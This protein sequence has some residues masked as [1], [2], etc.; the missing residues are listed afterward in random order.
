MTSTADLPK[1]DETLLDKEVTFASMALDARLLQAVARVGYEHPSLVQCEWRAAMCVLVRVR[2]V[3]CLLLVTKQTR[4][5]RG[6]RRVE[7]A[8]AQTKRS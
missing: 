2:G 4:R 6:T 8:H 7:L 3:A 5:L 1:C